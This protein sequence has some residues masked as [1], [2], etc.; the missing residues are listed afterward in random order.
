LSVTIDIT[1]PNVPTVG[2]VGDDNG[3]S[4]SD[5]ITNDQSL[6]IGGLAEA[7][8]S[9]EVFIDNTSVG[10][11]T[12][13]GQ[14]TYL[15]DYTAT[16]LSEGEYSITAKATDEAGNTSSASTA[17]DVTI[18]LTAPTVTITSNANDPQSGAFTATFTFSED[19][20]GFVEE[21]ISVG[22]GVASN[23]NTTSAKIYTATITPSADGDVDI[24][25]L[26]NKATDAAGNGNTAASQLTVVNDETAPSAPIVAS[27]S[28]DAGSS[29]TDGVTNDQTLEI[30]GTSEANA[31]IEVFIGG[32]SIGNTTADGA[33]DWTF[34]HTGSTLTEATHSITAKATDAAGNE[35]AESTAL[36]V[37]VDTSAPSVSS[38]TIVGKTYGLDEDVDVT[39]VFDEAVVVD[40]TNG[41]PSVTIAMGGQNRV[42]TYHSGSGT[43]TL[44]FRYTT[45]AGDLDGNGVSVL[46]ISLNGGTIQDVAGNNANTS[47]SVAGAADVRVDTSAPYM[48]ITSSSNAVSGAFTATF[49]FNE[50]VSGFDVSDISVGNGSVG[51]FNTTSAKIYT[52][53]ITPSTEGSVTVNVAADKAQDAG[54]NGNTA[55]SELRV[56]NDETSPTISI[57][58]STD[59]TNGAFSA[60]FTFSEDVSGFDVN[61]IAVG[62]GAAS[63][64]ATISASIYSATITPVTDG[65]VTVDVAVGAAHD[66]AG[67]NNSA[68]TQFSIT[69]D[70]TAPTV[71]E[72]TSDVNNATFKVGDDINIYVQYSEEVFVTGTPQLELE[73]GATDRTIDYVDRSSSTLRF[74]YSVQA[75]DVSSDLDVTSSSALT[76]N[77]GTI[78][79]AV[80]LN[81]DLAV[82]HG[83][84]GGSLTSKDI[85]IDGVAPTI[86]INSNASDPQSG[87]FTATFTFSENI[88]GFDVGD[89]S[90]GNGVASNFNTTSA[91]IYTALI[92]PSADGEV[93]IDVAADVATD[94]AGNNNTAATQLSVSNDETAPSV[95]ITSSADPTSGAFTATFTFSEDVSG[96]DISGITVGN[97]AASN[98]NTTTARIYTATITPTTDGV[99]TLNVA[100]GVALDAAGNNNS[101]ATQVSV[102]NDETAPTLVSAAKDSDTQ[103]TLTFN[104]AVETLGANPTDFTVTDENSSTFT[105][106]TVSDGTAGDTE[107]ILTFTD[108]IAAQLNLYINYANNNAV[109]TDLVGNELAST[110]GGVSISL[111]AVPTATNVDFSG[112]LTVG[113]TLT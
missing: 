52:A 20:S 9:V 60:T 37:T 86:T 85:V 44:V 84:E 31:S 54:G 40:E 59:R 55:A 21:D 46:S 56:V 102:T 76:L 50:D 101:A 8:S 94:V 103:I 1:A 12:T 87:P 88:S 107:L 89:I 92:T 97:G 38:G 71:L 35:S 3:S 91:K 69:N 113:E 90:V 4:N 95:T 75:G 98:F 45:V 72:V 42:A 23:F 111:N 10:T 63:N 80:G 70:E 93:T 41:T 77:G 81:A 30:S 58:S 67:N 48:S 83:T 57:T 39:Y 61:D 68:A 65:G 43:N 5:F 47:V 16:D 78:V 15:L 18:D 66:A 26:A 64:F 17:Q 29:N 112:T 110:R 104:E 19:I 11:T 33:G 62:N 108:L 109:V 32:N 73:T 24:D 99:V 36:D 6:V 28:T 82:Q 53:T 106:Q 27:I 7:N 13:N 22:N 79:D 49:T 96:F 25:V 74:V 105:V 2:A 14:G 34:D 100:N 51:S